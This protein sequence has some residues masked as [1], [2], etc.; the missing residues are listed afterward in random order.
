MVFDLTAMAEWLGE[1]GVP[2]CYPPTELGSESAITAVRD[3]DG[4]LVKE[5]AA[6]LDA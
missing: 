1:R 5:W 2:L 3:P 6:R 4:N